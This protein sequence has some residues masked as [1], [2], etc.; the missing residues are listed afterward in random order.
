MKKSA[1][2]RVPSQALRFGRKSA[3][4]WKAAPRA[5]ARILAMAAAAALFAA[6]AAFQRAGA[7]QP[8]EP[9]PA[10][11]A[12]PS[13]AARRVVVRFLTEG[14][15]PP[16]NFLDEEGV[17]T[18]FNVDLARALCLE[19]GAACDVNTRPWE[20]LIP[21]LKRGEADA[22]IA[23]HVISQKT[24]AE[25]DFSDRYF[26]MPGRFAA[27]RGEPPAEI[28]PEGL[29]EKHVAV[30]RGT[31]HEAF[32]KAFFPYSVIE[33]S[34]SA[35]L[36]REALMQG[37]T[38]YVFDDGVSLAF[39]LNGTNSKACCEFKGGPFLEPRYFGDG[40]AIAVSRNDPEM[41]KLLN[42]ALKRLRE[43]GRLEEL[44]Q[45]YFPY[46]IY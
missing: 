27:R 31:A 14:D 46:R 30:V 22:V 37:K 20:E 1:N 15:F 41:R 32:L 33:P 5:A 21:A 12:A 2:V 42:E 44:V 38:D 23:G 26:F 24:L 34:G 43:D 29:D 25:V 36:A 11:A 6:P 17:L 10:P 4:V 19:I 39:W 3:S 13:E 40:M 9:A 35:D 18:G 16:F 7:A 45:R 8:A 28:T